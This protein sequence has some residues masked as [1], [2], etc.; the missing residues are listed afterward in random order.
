MLGELS[1]LIY[2]IIFFLSCQGALLLGQ[3][4]AELLPSIHGFLEVEIPSVIGVVQDEI[5]QHAIRSPLCLFLSQP[6]IYILSK[7]LRFFK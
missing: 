4:P 1:P 2:Y 3:F 7:F 5:V 6:Y